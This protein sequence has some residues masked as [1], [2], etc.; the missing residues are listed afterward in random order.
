MIERYQ[1]A[2]LGGC[3]SLPLP[4]AEAVALARSMPA[5]YGAEVVKERR[6]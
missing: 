3:R 4:L 1:V 5:V 2:F 6:R